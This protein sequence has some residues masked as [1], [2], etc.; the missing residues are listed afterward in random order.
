[1]DPFMQQGMVP[2]M[3]PN[4]VDTSMTGEGQTLDQI[5]SQNDREIQ[6]RRSTYDPD[7]EQN[8]N[9]QSH[10]R[11]SSMLEFGS[12]DT[13]RADFQFDPSPPQPSMSQPM[14]GIGQPQKAS[15]P[16][17]IRPRENLAI[18]TRFNQMNSAFGTMSGYS[19]AMMTSTPL[20]L[21]PTSQ[22]LASNMEIPMN[23][24]NAS[25]EATPRN[26]QPQIEQQPYFTASPTHQ[27]FSPVFQGMN[28]DSPASRGPS[29]DQA[30][31]D[32]VSRMRAPDSMQNISAIS[33]QG[34]SP[35]HVMPTT[36]GNN[37]SSISSPARPPR[38]SIGRAGM[39]SPY[40]NGSTH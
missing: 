37:L 40:G 19:P 4:M 38:V 34:T 24:E 14:T 20:D 27:T 10:A 29:I 33:S 9:S 35:R 18:D 22:Y 2:N 28:R 6:R 36:R 8:G 21:D 5:I 23:F 17:K 32:K 26:I 16:R 11:R 1:M 12:K 13:E 31:M 7:F 3:A 15:D 39:R 30:I 25:G